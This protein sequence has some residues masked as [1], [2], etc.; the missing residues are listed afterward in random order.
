MKLPLNVLR[1]TASMRAEVAADGVVGIGTLSRRFEY[2]AHVILAALDHHGL[3][4][5][6]ITVKAVHSQVTTDQPYRIVHPR[7]LSPQRPTELAHL[8]GIAEVRWLVGAPRDEWKPARQRESNDQY[9]TTTPDAYWRRASGQEID[10]EY[11]RGTYASPTLRAKLAATVLRRRTYLYACAIPDRLL[12][13]QR[14]LRSIEAEMRRSGVHDLP[15]INLIL[16]RVYWHV[17]S[18]AER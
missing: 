11:D 4:T 14:E 7:P 17:G 5:S 9:G 13:L 6:V 15:P 18:E 1:A 8:A 3:C 16:Q 12:V 2:P 10:V